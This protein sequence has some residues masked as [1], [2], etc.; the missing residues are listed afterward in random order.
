MKIVTIVA[1]LLLAGC[2]GLQGKAE[3]IGGETFDALE[4]ASETTLKAVK[5]YHCRTARIGPLLEEYDTAEERDAWSVL[6]GRAL[7]LPE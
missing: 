4:N 7:V 2:A 5:R 3:D 1:M 6:C